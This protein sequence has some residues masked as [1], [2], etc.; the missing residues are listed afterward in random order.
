MLCSARSRIPAI[1]ARLTRITYRPAT[2]APQGTGE[3]REQANDPTPP[4]ES[5]NVSKTNEIGVT[6]VGAQDGVL[7]EKAAEGE[8]LRQLQAPNRSKTWSRSQQ[9][10][11][12]AMTGPRFEQTIM[13]Y[14]VSWTGLY[15][16]RPMRP[17]ARSHRAQLTSNQAA[18]LRRDRVDTQAACPVDARQS[19][20]LR[21]RWRPVRTSQDL[22][23]YR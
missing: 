9:P 16:I 15:N 23:Q 2:T 19:R 18:T 7:Q 4:K 13:E 21:W 22:Y 20:S 17:T 10:R 11:D 14:Q 1:A 6:A 3:N 5:P 12:R 8:R